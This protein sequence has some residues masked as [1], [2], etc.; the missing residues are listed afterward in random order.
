MNVTAWSG[1]HYSKNEARCDINIRYNRLQNSKW[2]ESRKCS[3]KTATE[4]EGMADGGVQHRQFPMLCYTLEQNKYILC[5]HAIWLLQLVQLLR[6][7]YCKSVS[8]IHSLAIHLSVWVI[9]Q[10]LLFALTFVQTNYIISLDWK[11][12]CY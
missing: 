11:R 10:W 12:N 9:A 1:K 2:T 3:Y 4:L 6:K 5:M 8:E 7:I